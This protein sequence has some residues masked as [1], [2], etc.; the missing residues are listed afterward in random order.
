M[1]R[2]KGVACMSGM[3]EGGGMRMAWNKMGRQN[4]ATNTNINQKA[5]TK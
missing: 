1:R 3:A 2:A 5:Q 4:L